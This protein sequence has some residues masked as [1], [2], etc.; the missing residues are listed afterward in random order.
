MSEFIIT[1]FTPP[2]GYGRGLTTRDYEQFPV[3][4]NSK[5]FDLPLIPESEWQTRLD[6]QIAAKAQLHNIRDKGN[7]GKPIP[8]TDQQQTNF[9]W[10]H[11][12]VGAVILLRATQGEPYV[13]LSA[14]AVA[15]KIKNFKNVGGWGSQ[16]LEYIAA[17]GVPDINHWAQGNAGINKHYDS[18]ETWQNAAKHKVTEWMDLQPRN[19]QQFVT[20][21]LNNI[22]VVTDLNH[23]G[24][25]VVTMSILSFNPFRTLIWNSWSD[26]WGKNGTGILEG[27][28]AIPDGAIAP[29]VTFGG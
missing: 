13:P 11:S 3:G 29:R 23:W 21:L 18:D 15:C 8:S 5:P 20:C 26:A 25:S 4:Y 7:D 2:E 16:S 1:D 22:P 19:K 17:H 28:K 6:Q 14:T 27:S 24:H 12:S 10:A 9:C